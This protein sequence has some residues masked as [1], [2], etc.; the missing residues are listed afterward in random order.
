M[1]KTNS[2]VAQAFVSGGKA[3]KGSNTLYDRMELPRIPFAVRTF[4]SYSTLVAVIAEGTLWWNDYRSNSTRRQLSYVH[5][6]WWTASVG[7]DALS[8]CVDRPLQGASDSNV[9]SYV[10]KAED[11]LQK[12]LKP[13]IR[14]TTKANHWGEFLSLVDRTELLLTLPCYSSAP[15][16]TVMK[17]LDTL[18]RI[19]DSNASNPVGLDR[20]ITN[21]R[22]IHA[23][24]GN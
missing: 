9:C 22:A 14:N 23:L 10:V 18:R 4:T 16:K 20:V 2:E 3:C 19:R 6:A 11:T 1:T 7:T 13:R 24:E 17:R 8:M 12:L 21:V 15:S 5:A